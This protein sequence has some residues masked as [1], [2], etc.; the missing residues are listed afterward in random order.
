MQK[1]CRNNWLSGEAA[2]AKIGPGHSNGKVLPSAELWGYGSLFMKMWN[3]RHAITT[4]QSYMS[5]NKELRSFLRNSKIQCK[6]IGR[7]P[8]INLLLETS[9]SKFSSSHPKMSWQ[10]LPA[11]T[12]PR[13]FRCRREDLEFKSQA[14]G[15][16]LSAIQLANFG[17]WEDS[18]FDEGAVGVNIKLSLTIWIPLESHLTAEISLH[19]W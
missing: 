17:H 18:A 19:L 10:L 11:L 6:K 15:R 8:D 16:Q 12:G 7:N 4:F 3:V 1:A 2:C 14:V 9:Y 5:G 13:A